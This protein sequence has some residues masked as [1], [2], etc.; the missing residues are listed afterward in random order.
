MESSEPCWIKDGLGWPGGGGSVPPGDQSSGWVERDRKESLDCLI[1]PV[2]DIKIK[3]F[4]LSLEINLYINSLV[5]KYKYVYVLHVKKSYL[6][7]RS[8]FDFIFGAGVCIMIEIKSG[9]VF[10]LFMNARI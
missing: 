3:M 10:M 5:Q 2:G 1:I 8:V 4:S 6:M 9:C 7:Q